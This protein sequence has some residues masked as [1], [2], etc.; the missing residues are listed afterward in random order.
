M[1]QRET[2]SKSVDLEPTT[3]II[4]LNK[5]VIISIKG[6]DGQL[7]YRKSKTWLYALHKKSTLNVKTKLK[8]NGYNGVNH[9]NMNQKKTGVAL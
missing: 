8:V 1:G 3:S 4:T 6:R 5:I 2:N 9:A 7:G